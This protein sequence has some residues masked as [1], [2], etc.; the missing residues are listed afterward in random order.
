M[1]R[2]AQ[3]PYF[4][5]LPCSCDR[6]WQLRSKSERSGP[7]TKSQGLCSASETVFLRKF[8]VDLLDT[9]AAIKA[10]RVMCPMTVDRLRPTQAIVEALRFFPRQ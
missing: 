10:V 1:L 4:P 5:N 9:V 6:S 8:N 7:T 2:E 3:A